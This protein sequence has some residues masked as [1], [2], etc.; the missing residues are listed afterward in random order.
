MQDVQI[1]EFPA[2][3][4]DLVPDLKRILLK[5]LVMIVYTAHTMLYQQRGHAC[6]ITHSSSLHRSP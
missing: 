2:G 6:P 5:K 1:R 3:L 4:V